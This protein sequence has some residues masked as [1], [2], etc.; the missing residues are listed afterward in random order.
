MSQFKLN[1]PAIDVNNIISDNLK[2]QQLGTSTLSFNLSQEPD[3]WTFPSDPTGSTL[4]NL[5]LQPGSTSYSGNLDMSG[6]PNQVFPV[7]TTVYAFGVIPKEPYGDI[8]KRIRVTVTPGNVEASNFRYWVGDENNVI[9]VQSTMSED[10][11]LRAAQPNA[12]FIIYIQNASSTT[13]TNP[14]FNYLVTTHN[15]NWL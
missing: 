11:K 7:G 4:T 14:N 5:G 1:N 8:N 15:V 9:T 12:G 6:T 2:I 3:V 13:Q 10:L